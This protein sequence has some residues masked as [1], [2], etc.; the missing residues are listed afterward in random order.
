VSFFNSSVLLVFVMIFNSCTSH[1]GPETIKQ[2]RQDFNI[3]LQ[4]TSDEQMLLNLVR[5]KY[6]DTGMFLEVSSIAS[7]YVLKNSLA[8]SGDFQDSFSRSIGVGA[9][10]SYEEKPTVSYTPLQGQKF[11]T[12]MLTRV[13]PATLSLLHG[14]GWSIERLFLVCVERV[15]SVKN[16]P[17]ASGP[18]PSYVP[19]YK[20]FQ[21]FAK[22]LRRLQ[23]ADAIEGQLAHVGKYPGF[24]MKMN[25]NA[26]AA[27]KK[28]F[29]DILGIKEQELYVFSGNRQAQTEGHIYFE[30]RSLREVL[31]YLSQGVTAPQ[32]HIDNGN[33]TL[34]KYNDGKVFDWR[35]LTKDVLIVKS[36][37]GLSPNDAY[38]RIHYRN[39]WYYIADNDLNTKSTFNLL[40]QLYNLQAGNTQT[41]APVLTLPIG[42]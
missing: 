17:S 4:K 31:F 37:D 41:S 30:T 24:I 10:I 20:E 1:V 14:S 35:E 23:R 25:E 6:R 32:E 38:V 22:V 15:N 13:S 2:E 39:H 42:G 3:A 40:M 36:K 33:V 5:M 11:I 26:S 27:D 34:T 12:R 16:A 28:E 21:R 18:T 8:A 29:L 7:Q 19:E 9:G